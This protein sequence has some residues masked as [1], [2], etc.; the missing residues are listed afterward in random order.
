MRFDANCSAKKFKSLQQLDNLDKSINHVYLPLSTKSIRRAAELWAK[1]RETGV[2][3]A[4]DKALDADVI[5]AAQALEYSG[6]A[7]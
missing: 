7:D 2:P 6:E 5:L 1:A 4:E 3:T